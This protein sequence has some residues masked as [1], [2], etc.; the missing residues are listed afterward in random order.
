MPSKSVVGIVV[1]LFGLLGLSQFVIH[2]QLSDAIIASPTIDPHLTNVESP[3]KHQLR[4]KPLATVA[5]PDAYF[6]GLPLVYHDGSGEKLSSSVHCMGESHM[7]K[8]AW[9]YRS[10][11]YRNLCFDMTSGEFVLFASPKQERLHATMVAIQQNSSELSYSSTD[12]LSNHTEVSIGGHTKWWDA[13]LKSRIKWRP[14]TITGTA[15]TGYYMLPSNTVWLPFH[16]LAGVNPGHLLWDNFFPLYNLLAFFGLEEKH[17]LVMRYILNPPQSHDMC[18]RDSEVVCGKM[19]KKFAVIFGISPDTLTDNRNVRFEVSKTKDKRDQTENQRLS[20]FVCAP[21]GAAGIGDL[22]DHG[23]E[24]KTHGFYPSDYQI[25][26]MSG[27]S[28]AL[29]DFR[30]YQIANVLG[31][32]YLLNN[33]F[34][35]GSGGQLLYPILFSVGSSTDAK[36]SVTFETQIAATTEHFADQ[37]DVTIEAV[38]F[39]KMSIAEQMRKAKSAAIVVTTCGGGAISSMWQ[40]RDSTLILF[41][42]VKGRHRHPDLLDWEWWD[43]AAYLKVHWLPLGTANEKPDV[44]ALLNIMDHDIERLRFES[45]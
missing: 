42:P 1:G 44:E 30:N 28:Q 7:N 43:H 32:D 34:Q 41:F 33:G 14:K 23:V 21:Y 45:Q 2:E 26:Q 18:N 38:T 15:P 17:P 9:M 13:T 8:R 25:Q 22:N 5:N 6:N 16:N 4:S 3:K 31:V 11:Q 36:R 10:C 27:R 24:L 19:M 29:W 37:D 35:N 40:Q 20:N 12:M 39:A